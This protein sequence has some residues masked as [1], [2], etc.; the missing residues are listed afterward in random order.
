[1]GT[2]DVPAGNT[3]ALAVIE[4]ASVRRYDPRSTTSESPDYPLV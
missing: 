2:A 4:K 1:M 3:T